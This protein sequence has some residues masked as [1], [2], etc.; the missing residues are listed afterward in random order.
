MWR[1]CIFL[2]YRKKQ[3]DIT[4]IYTGHKLRTSDLAFRANLD[5]MESI[6][7]RVKSREYGANIVKLYHNYF[8]LNTAVGQHY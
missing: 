4:K 3:C 2:L 7:D 6:A 1:L 5:F 8:I